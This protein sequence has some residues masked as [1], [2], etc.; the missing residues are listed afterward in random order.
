[1]A[2]SH[3]FP[4]RLSCTSL[5]EL[6]TVVRRRHSGI[7]NQRHKFAIRLSHFV[8]EFITPSTAHSDHPVDSIHENPHCVRYTLTLQPSQITT[9]RSNGWRQSISSCYYVLTQYKLVTL[10]AAHSHPN[11]RRDDENITTSTSQTTAAVCRRC[12]RHDACMEYAVTGLHRAPTTG[13]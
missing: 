5:S 3:I 6:L 7:A 9:R 10:V 2:L 12:I 1:M 11:C 4:K 13:I 8:A